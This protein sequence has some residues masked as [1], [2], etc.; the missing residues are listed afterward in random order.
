MPKFL[1]DDWDDDT[2]YF[3]SGGRGRDVFGISYRGRHDSGR[4]SGPARVVKGG[5]VI[6][7]P[8]KGKHSSGKPTPRNG[9]GK[10]G[11]K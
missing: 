11:K 9:G 8:G 4:A 6:R 10:G 1:G 3:T 2:S 7:E 5:K